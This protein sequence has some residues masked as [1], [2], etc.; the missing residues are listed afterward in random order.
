MKIKDILSKAGANIIPFKQNYMLKIGD[1]AIYCG[2]V[3]KIVAF[4]RRE[5]Q[6]TIQYPN[7]KV[8]YP[9]KYDKDLKPV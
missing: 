9:D 5:N 6:Y 7:G 3:G 1:E 8:N 4:D 2:K